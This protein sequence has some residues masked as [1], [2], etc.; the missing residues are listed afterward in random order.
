M[1]ASVEI[2]GIDDPR[3]RRFVDA[4]PDALAFHHPSWAKLLAECY[5]FRP[6]ALAT[7][8]ADGE[9][10]TGIP[11][12]EVSNVIRRKRWVA[13]P[14]TDACPPLIR[15]PAVLTSFVERLDA[16]RADAGIAQL[17][18][19]SAL[20]G[21]LAT[22]GARAVTHSL[23]LDPDPD[24]VLRK[25]H[26]SKVRQP[27]VRAEREGVTVRRADSRKDLTDVYYRLH[28]ATR[29]RLGVPAQPR[30]FFDLLWR[31]MVEPQLGF[32]LLAYIRNT[33][34]AGAVFLVSNGTTTYKFSASDPRYWNSRPNHLVLWSAIRWSCE[35]SRRLFDFGRTELEHQ[36][37]REFKRGWGTREE[38]L[39]YSSLGAPATS[40]SHGHARRAVTTV[41]RRSPSWVCRA[42]GSA[43]YRY[44]A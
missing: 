23:Q 13:L 40:A 9:I 17:E 30:R 28:V 4:S 15:D 6:F 39:L 3:W 31:R 12:L 1:P 32:A 42:V 11:V 24:V 7:S 20:A 19:R 34:V 14:F 25:L 22:H 10:D 37:L 5:G 41:I 21:P 26:P 2:V 16:A 36:G 18:V 43:L 27:I 8:D 35:N 29:N 44:A 38:P 33:P